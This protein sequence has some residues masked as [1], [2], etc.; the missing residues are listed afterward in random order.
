ML[1]QVGPVLGQ[2]GPRQTWGQ[3]MATHRTDAQGENREGASTGKGTRKIGFGFFWT[4]RAHI[5]DCEVLLS[6]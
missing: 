1:G 4:F 5:E 2:V 3:P 6:K